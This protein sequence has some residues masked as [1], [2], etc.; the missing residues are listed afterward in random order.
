MSYLSF[1]FTHTDYHYVQYYRNGVWEEGKLKQDH[2]LSLPAMATALHYGQEAFEGLKAFKR[3]DGRVQIFRPFENAKRF[4]G[5]CQYLLMPLVDVNDFV[6]AVIKTVKANLKYVPDYDSGGAL[7]IRPYMIGAGE[8]LAPT[9]SP[10]YI[11]GVVVTPVKSLFKGTLTPVDLWVSMYDRVAPL[12]TGQ[13]KVGG[14]Y[15]ASMFAQRKASEL[16]YDD[17]LFLDPLTHTKIEEVGA[18]NFFGITKNNDYV[19]PSS[20][21]ILKSITNKSLKYIAENI[22]NMR[23]LD[24][25]IRIDDLSEFVEAG[26]CGTAAIITP[27]RSIAYKENIHIFPTKDH[28]GKT[29]KQLYD[30]LTGIQK[31]DYKDPDHWTLLVE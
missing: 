31:G 26:A 10:S 16:G 20:P 30:I 15:A 19:S 6:A 4:Q 13:Y 14:N 22:L 5:S 11:F 1:K 2:T 9:P 23:V 8:T 3:K 21:S 25:D 27:I 12:G 28:A 7:Y 24:H 18:A 17:A 29:T